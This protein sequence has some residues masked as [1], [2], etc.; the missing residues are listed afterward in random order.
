MT[1]AVSTWYFF[2][3]IKN[4]I[5]SAHQHDTDNAVEYYAAINKRKVCTV[6]KIH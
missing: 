6:F 5:H 4:E 1:T 2:G 3:S